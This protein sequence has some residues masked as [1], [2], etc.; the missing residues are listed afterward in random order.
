MNQHKAAMEIK[1]PI[2]LKRVAI[3]P[4][5]ALL[6]F[7]LWKKE[8]ELSENAQI[9]QIVSKG[10]VAKQNGNTA[11]ASQAFHEALNKST[12]F[13]NE[14]KITSNEHLNHRVFIYDQIANMAMEFGDLQTAEAVFKDT[15]KL[16]LQLGMAEND[17]A[18]IEMS[19]KLSTIYL[20]TGRIDLGV[21]G[22]KHC[23]TEQETK[24][25]EKPAAASDSKPVNTTEIKEEEDN[26]RVLL[27]KALKHLANYHLQKRDFTKAESLMQKSLEISRSILGDK[28]DNT[29]VIMNDIATCL[30]MQEEYGKAESLLHE[31][32]KLSGKAKSLMQSALLSNL[33][34]LYIRTKKFD[35][36]KS[37]CERGLKV[38]EKGNDAFLKK[39]CQACLS[40][41]AELKDTEPKED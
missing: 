8:E 30:I 10:I 35:K 34:A 37:A 2:N 15:M 25:K 5:L 40:R 11:G 26:T 1:I 12:D 22:L 38:A 7:N 24:L 39:P 16:A 4:S 27:G 28:H 29:F 33:G 23:I 9:R 36:A 14:K 18:M 6:G 17:N 19:L 13:L 32:I 41:L 3:G 31:G 21:L 20:Y